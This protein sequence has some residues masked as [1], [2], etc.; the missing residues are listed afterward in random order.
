MEPLFLNRWD[1]DRYAYYLSQVRRREICVLSTNAETSLTVT[2]QAFVYIFSGSVTVVV[3][4][5]KFNL[6]THEFFFARE[7]GDYKLHCGDEDSQVLIIDFDF[8]AFNTGKLLDVTTLQ[9]LRINLPYYL[10][11]KKQNTVQFLFGSIIKEIGDPAVGSEK[12]IASYLT[13]I[14]LHALRASK[15]SSDEALINISGAAFYSKGNHYHP[16]EAGRKIWFTDVHIW[17]KKVDNPDV[18]SSPYLLGLLRAHGSQCSIPGDDSAFICT[19]EEPYRQLP[20]TSFEVT[21][22]TPYHIWIW[23]SLQL[24][25]DMRPIQND[26]C[27]TFYIKSNMTGNI[28]FCLCNINNFTDVPDIIAIDKKS[29]WIPVSISGHTSSETV[30]A[31]PYVIKSVMYI[32]EHYAKTLRL[33]EIADHVHISSIHLSRLF[34]EQT[35]TTIT[36]FISL[37]RIQMAKTMLSTTSS[38]LE[39]IAHT[40]GFYDLQHFSRTFIRYTGMRPSAFRKLNSNS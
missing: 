32:K 26:Y 24:H 8:C 16:M 30:P 40:V 20:V 11:L 13:N 38:T 28:G 17:S 21:K 29:T 14:I 2:S 27:I 10:P 23:P 39:K 34:K 25:L 37:H 3:S 7:S 4:D 15:R 35:G 12:L 36:D 5:K 9:K 22:R 6:Q 18:E 33:E 19:N 31:S 1:V